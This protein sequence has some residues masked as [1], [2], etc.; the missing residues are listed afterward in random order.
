MSHHQSLFPD[1][2][3]RPAL[4]LFTEADDDGAHASADQ[5]LAEFLESFVIPVCLV[6]SKPRNLKQYRE[7]V[8][9]WTELTGGP[10]LS[11]I[12]D[13]TCAQFVSA[14]RKLTGRGKA[15]LAENTVRKH[16]VAVQYVLDRA[17]PRSRHNRLGRGLIAEAPL[18]QKPSLVVNEVEDNF[19]LWEIGRWL[20]AA[21]SATAPRLPGLRPADWWRA[22]GLFAYNAGP[23]I[24]TLTVLRFSWLERDEIGWWAKVPKGAAPKMR[25]G[26]K[27]YLSPAALGAIEPLRGRT[28]ETAD[29]IFPWPHSEGYLHDCRRQLLAASE[30]PAARHFGFHGLRKA[31]ETELARINAMAASWAAGHADAPGKMAREHYVHR[32]I[33][34]AA[35]DR[36]P[37]PV[38]TPPADPQ[39]LL[40]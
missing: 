30:I 40:W 16:C 12:D 15:P 13:Y 7:S 18:I 29:L 8:G 20:E 3:P 38:W 14:L 34:C 4:R 6:N 11:G 36:L 35:I 28:G 17:G 37:Q 5:T 32:A 2:A 25:N 26:G 9:Y 21:E 27:I 22:I 31:F 39:R 24:G 10:P 33:F 1:Q 19:T 23:R